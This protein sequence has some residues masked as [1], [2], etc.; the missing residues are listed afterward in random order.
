MLYM[1][2]LSR[3]PETVGH[4]RETNASLAKYEAYTAPDSAASP[5]ALA[6]LTILSMLIIAQ[7]LQ[8]GQS[9]QDR[10]RAPRHRSL[11]HWPQWDSQ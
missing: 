4:R 6:T 3:R 2:A 7:Y 8:S 9:C 10:H 5:K 1:P 11:D